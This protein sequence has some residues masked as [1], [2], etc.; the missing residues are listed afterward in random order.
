[1]TRTH[2]QR[3][4]DALL[5]DVHQLGAE[6]ERAVSQA[7]VAFKQGNRR[8]ARL[9]L[10][11]DEKVNRAQYAINAALILMARQAP[12]ATDLRLITSIMVVAGELERIS[13]HAEN[14]IET[15]AWSTAAPTP[16]LQPE[17]V[18]MT[19]LAQQMVRT[20]LYVYAHHHAEVAR[21]LAAA[22]DVV[23]NLMVQ[24]KTALPMRIAEHPTESKAIMDHWFLA[25]QFERIADHA[26]N[27]GEQAI[28]VV[29]GEVVDLNVGRA[30]RSDPVKIADMSAVVELNGRRPS[31]A[32]EE[33]SE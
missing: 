23:D 31:M 18:R 12:V 27:I 21:Q 20:A 2:Y 22:D 15:V 30:T 9:L 5:H 14:V 17:L 26:T 33:T 28:F 32:P 24:L 29:T 13:D 10:A 7:I 8:M 19:E 11:Y 3:Q 16:E 6:V 1:M 25:L 4:L